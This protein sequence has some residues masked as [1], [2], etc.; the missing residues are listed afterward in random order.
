MPRMDGT[1]PWGL[2]PL[3]GRGLGPCGWGLR[4]APGWGWASGW[5]RWYSAGFTREELLQER[6]KLLERQLGLIEE[7]LRA[8]Q[9][10]EHEE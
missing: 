8:V 1:G 3:T 6:K 2:G 10:E 9:R 7:E 4:T 5:R